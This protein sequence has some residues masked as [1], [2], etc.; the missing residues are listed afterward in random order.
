MGRGARV[1]AAPR[2]AIARALTEGKRALG[3]LQD[4]LD[5][6]LARLRQ[7]AA[8]LDA[9][10]PDRLAAAVRRAGRAIAVLDGV[11]P[12]AALS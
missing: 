8:A 12:P 4:E 1:A 10:A 6:L 3:E 9:Q 11:A 5:R 7:P 2:P